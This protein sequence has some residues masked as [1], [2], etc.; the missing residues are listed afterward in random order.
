[1]KY[2]NIKYVTFTMYVTVNLN[3]FGKISSHFS[4]LDLI[5]LSTISNVAPVMAFFATYHFPNF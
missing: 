4:D 2:N 1:M 5:M 3:S